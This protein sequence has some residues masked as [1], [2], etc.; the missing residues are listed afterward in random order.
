MKYVIGLGNPELCYQNTK[1][2]IGYMVL[3]TFLSDYQ[4]VWIY[5]D[6]YAYI[7]CIISDDNLTEEVMLI[8]PCTGMNSCGDIFK[9]LPIQIQDNLIVIFDNMDLSI[10]KYKCRKKGSAHGHHGLDSIINAISTEEFIHISIGIGKPSDFS[11][12]K[13]YALT[14]FINNDINKINTVLLQIS[15]LLPYICLYGT[16][17]PKAINYNLM[18]K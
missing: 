13:D 12:A 9:Y 2:N 10:G 4:T 11:K 3:N 14:P 17:N 15:D 1:H 18:I 16:D 6:N 8:K 7:N 5:K